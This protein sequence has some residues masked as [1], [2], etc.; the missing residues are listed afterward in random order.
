MREELE[1]WF[2]KSKNSNLIFF[3]RC[4]YTIRLSFEHLQ[5]WIRSKAVLVVVVEF[6][7][8]F[9]SVLWS[10]SF[11]FCFM[12]C[13][14]SSFFPKY[15]VCF[16]SLKFLKNQLGGRR[17]GGGTNYRFFS[18]SVFGFVHQGSIVV[19][20][21]CSTLVEVDRYY[22]IFLIIKLNFF[23]CV[24]LLFISFVKIMARQEK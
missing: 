7:L 18:F 12:K 5:N 23:V 14:C 13:S 22:N 17:G 2:G 15:C 3:C 1:V 19:V 20:V 9:F 10:S 6:F 21:I 16:F 8:F 11:S 4:D 24:E